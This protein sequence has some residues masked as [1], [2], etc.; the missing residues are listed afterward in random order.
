M[1]PPPMIT[2]SG[3]LAIGLSPFSI[4]TEPIET[5]VFPGDSLLE[6]LSFA[7]QADVHRNQRPDRLPLQAAGDRLAVPTGTAMPDW[8][9]PA[10]KSEPRPIE[11][12]PAIRVSQARK[13]S[14]MQ[15]GELINSTRRMHA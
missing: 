3:C 5:S 14:P 8:L 6:W 2:T 13:P 12:G 7:V 11:A 15:P 4:G 9:R 10:D 1:A